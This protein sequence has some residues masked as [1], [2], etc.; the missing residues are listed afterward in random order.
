MKTKP[1]TPTEELIAKRLLERDELR[2]ALELLTQ[3]AECVADY[4]LRG[5]TRTTW[6]DKQSISPPGSVANCHA[7][8]EA[9]VQARAALNATKSPGTKAP[10]IKPKA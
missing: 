4:D 9:I 6:T 10:V 5:Q 8:S 2:K 7:L 1:L 3:R